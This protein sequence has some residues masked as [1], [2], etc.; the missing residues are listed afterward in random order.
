MS[1]LN[2]DKIQPIGGGSTITVDATDIQATSATITASKFVGSGDLSVTGVSTFTGAI[3]ANGDLDVDGHTD[4]DNVSIAGVSTFTGAIDANGDLDVDGHTNLDNVSI[5]GVST[6]TNKLRIDIANG[7]TAGSGNAEGIFLRNTQETDNNAVTIFS[8]A[9]D[10]NTAASAINF[11]NVDH[12]ANY[13]DISFDT[14]GSGGYGE[15]VRIDSSGK[16][17]VGTTA[18]GSSGVDNLVLYRNGNGGI[19]IRNNANQNGNLFFSRGTSGTDEYKGYIQYQH[20]NDAMV[21]ATSHTEKVRITSDGKVGIGEDAPQQK[22]HLHEASSNGNFMVFTNSTTGATGNDGCLFGINSDEGGTIWNQ[23]NG[24]IRFGTNNTERLRIQ[25]TGQILYQAASGDNQ[26]TSKRTNTAGS[27]G[28]YF[29]HLKATAGDDTEVGGF[30]FHRDTNTD[31]ARFIVKT[32]NT[33]GSSQERL[34]I[35]SD[36]KLSLG[37]SS[38]ASA[39]FNISHGNEFALYTSGPYNFQAKFEST[40]AEAAIVIEDSNSTNDGNRIGVITNDMTFITN[41]TEKLRIDSD[42]NLK[43]LTSTPTAFTS[44][45]PNKQRF[46][47]KKCMQGSCTSTTTLTGSGTGV[48][49]L[50]RLWLTDDSSTELFIQVMRN[51]STNHNTHY[52]KAFIQKVRGTGMSHGHVLYQAGAASGFS[53][54]SIQAGGYTGSGGSSHGTEIHVSGGAGGVIYRMVCFYTTISKNDMY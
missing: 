50:G 48:F 35:H 54:T 31:D 22:L 45:A 1:I 4:L 39:K 14:R 21:L 2:V 47:G 32:R 3:D 8:G 24:Y 40:D 36:G 15:R 33:G 42:G 49:D 43:H 41:D 7:G 51:D 6:F 26:I 30:G 34:R 53:I 29:F 37:T 17:L 5:A 16:L 20:G 12:S 18:A 23:E 13:G 11:V 44:S 38:S 52:A 46:L 19:T 25:S 10:Y 28:N 27:N 9:D